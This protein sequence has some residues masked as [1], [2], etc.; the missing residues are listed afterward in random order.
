V[1]KR[2]NWDEIVS[3]FIQ[4]GRAGVYL[5]K[6]PSNLVPDILLVHTTNEDGTECSETWAQNSGAGESPKINN[7]TFTTRRNSKIK[8]NLFLISVNRH[9]VFLGG[10]YCWFYQALKYEKQ[11][12]LQMNEVIYTP[13]Y[14][15]ER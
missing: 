6:Y 5:Y 11:N 4:V 13:L 12:L 10:Y 8:N 7:T 15:S 14:G 2:N 1:N 3:V 9:V